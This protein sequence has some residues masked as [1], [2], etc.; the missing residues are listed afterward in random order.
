MYMIPHIGSPE[1]FL[2]LTT[3]IV[4]SLLPAGTFS[5]T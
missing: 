1:V 4:T 3:L 5:K 2:D